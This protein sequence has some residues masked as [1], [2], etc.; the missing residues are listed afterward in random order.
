MWGPLDIDL[1]TTW[2]H[3]VSLWFLS[4]ELTWQRRTGNGVLS[5]RITFRS[6]RLWCQT[7]WINIVA[8]RYFV[9]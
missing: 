8:Y 9:D 4:F 2:H 3:P 6:D 5:D 1:D 7:T